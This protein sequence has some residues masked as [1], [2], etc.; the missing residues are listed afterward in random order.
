MEQLT[1]MAQANPAIADWLHAGA[2]PAHRTRRSRTPRRVLARHG[3]LGQGW[4]DLQLASGPRTA[5]LY[6]DLAKRVDRP[7]ERASARRQRL[8]DE[9]DHL[10]NDLRAGAD[11]GR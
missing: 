9:A 3:H 2:Q 11:D 10:L 8:A 1:D 5:R 6:D 7:G 4:D